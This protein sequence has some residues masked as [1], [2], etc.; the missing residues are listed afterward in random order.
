VDGEETDVRNGVCFD[1]WRREGIGVLAVGLVLVKGGLVC[2]GEV[3]FGELTE[4]VEQLIRKVG[5][6]IRKV[7]VH[8]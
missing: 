7:S 5:T 6:S 2:E 1:R 8:A 4:V 3:V